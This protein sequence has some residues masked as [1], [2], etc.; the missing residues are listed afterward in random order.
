MVWV[1]VKKYLLVKQTSNGI[2]FSEATYLFNNKENILCVPTNTNAFFSKFTGTLLLKSLS[3]GKISHITY[4]G[5]VNQPHVATQSEGKAENRTSSCHTIV[6][7][8]WTGHCATEPSSGSMTYGTTTDGIGSCESPTDDGVGCSRI[9]W[10]RTGSSSQTYCASDPGNP[11]NPGD[12][13]NPGGPGST[14][15]LETALGADKAALFGPC[16]G[17]TD[18][19]RPLINY[20]PPSAV[21]SRLNTLAAQPSLAA[22]IGF[23]KCNPSKMLGELQLTLI[24]FLLGSHLC[25]T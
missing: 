3:T 6:T 16:P 9:V 25:L 20:I 24:F 19:W 11:G 10:T 17:L 4:L 13:G 22:S 23:G 18:G 5:G 1:G 14:T 15:S 12:P 8:Y 7:C 2:D 21:I